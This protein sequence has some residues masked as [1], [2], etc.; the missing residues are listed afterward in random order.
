[1]SAKGTLFVLS[2]PSGGG[3]GTILATVLERDPLLKKSVSATTRSPRLDEEDGRHYHFVD[4][5]RFDAWIEEGKFAE[6]AKVHSN[7]YGTLREELDRQLAT[8]SD[9]VLEL[10][11][12]GMR[13][14]K[15]QRGDL[16]SIFVAAPSF[17]ELERRLRARG[18][19][20]EDE[21]AIRMRT[22]R[23]EMAHKDAYDYVIVN[24]VLDDAV[25]NFES[26]I[27]AT[28]ESDWCGGA[29]SIG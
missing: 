23:E 5:A 18:G 21:I 3:K 29:H 26:I 16:V 8:G 13:S 22:A 1:V 27:R 20:T 7:R 24:D 9:V 6:W 25:A 17:D 15:S 2:A 28:R 10:D 11:V 19:L 12:Q 14:L 4:D